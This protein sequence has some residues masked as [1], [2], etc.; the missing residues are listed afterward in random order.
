MVPL[1]HYNTVK[2]QNARRIIVDRLTHFPNEVYNH[3]Y[4]YLLKPCDSFRLQCNMPNAELLKAPTRPDQDMTHA[5]L[6]KY[7]WRLKIYK[8]HM[9]INCAT[10]E[11]LKIFSDG[12]VGKDV[13]YKRLPPNLTAKK[14][15]K[16]IEKMTIKPF[17]KMPPST[18]YNHQARK[19][20][21]YCY[22][23]SSISNTS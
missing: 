19:D 13:E 20:V 7:A 4:P 8:K 21:L 5:N 15:Y 6:R 3:R 17:V 1:I 16:C 9:E 18:Y 11:L 10:V 12:L 14:A 22:N 23:F 2:I